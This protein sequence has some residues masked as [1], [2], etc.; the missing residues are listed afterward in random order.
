M[1]YFAV[2]DAFH[3]HPKVMALRAGSYEAEALAVWA[4]AGS[5]CNA[6]LTDGRIPRYVVEGL[7]RKNALKAAAELVRVGLWHET[8]DGWVFH[9][10]DHHQ[11]TAEERKAKRSE[12]RERMRNVRREKNGTFVDSSRERSQ[13]VRA[14]K[15]R[16]FTERSST[17]AQ[18][19][20]IPEE[21]AHALSTCAREAP[22]DGPP[23]QP[24]RSP[25]A[26]RSELLRMGY[27]ERHAVKHPGVRP[28]AVAQPMS[29]GPWLDVA[30]E[31]SDADVAKLLDA[32][33]A[34]EFCS[35]LRPNKLRSERV[36]L[37]TQGA[38][39]AVK[40]GQ[41]KPNDASVFKQQLAEGKAH[42]ESLL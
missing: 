22:P 30:R 5:W 32:F 3:S 29:G 17:P 2:D 24:Q 10:W 4:K 12:A 33:F 38:R 13:S 36:R 16:T 18:P 9:Q 23:T 42:D 31:I 35:D 15:P 21:S 41:A 19:I 26:L 39:G 20:P 1:P 25:V 40:R 14:N 37:L 28:D 11:F 6:G 8:G 7:L 27:L 34:D